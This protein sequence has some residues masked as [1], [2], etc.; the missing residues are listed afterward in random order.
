MADSSS[1]PWALDL[2]ADQLGEFINDLWGAA[3]AENDLE[4]LAA[5]EKVIAE[6]RPAAEQA[7]PS[8]LSERDRAVLTGLAYGATYDALAERLGVAA[9][10]IE[11]LLPSICEQL[12]VE[13]LSDAIAAASR[14]GWIPELCVPASAGRRVGRGQRAWHRHLSERVAEMQAKPGAA[15]PIGPYG[16]QSGAWNAARRINK[17]L[18]PEV[19]PAGAFSAQVVVSGPNEWVVETRYLGDPASTKEQS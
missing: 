13:C 19:Q 8:L 5:V 15:V 2:S 9:T 18:W 12:E 10:T 14:R 6:Y 4:A 17:G 11:R 1:F 3:A 16:S 7:A